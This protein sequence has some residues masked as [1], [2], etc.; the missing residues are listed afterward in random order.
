MSRYQM[1]FFFMSFWE[2]MPQSAKRASSSAKYRR[3]S[4]GWLGLNFG[5]ELWPRYGMTEFEGVS[6]LEGI[7]EGV[8]GKVDEESKDEVEG[9]IID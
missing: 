4:R 6:E 2:V 5:A 7:V 9:V 8:S 1:A 3:S